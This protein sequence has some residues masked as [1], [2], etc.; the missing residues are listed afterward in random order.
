V[1]TSPESV[2]E[3]FQTCCSPPTRLLKPSASKIIKSTD[4]YGFK[5]NMLF[6]RGRLRSVLPRRVD[7]YQTLPRC[8]EP[9]CQYVNLFPHVHY[10]NTYSLLLSD[11][12]ETIDDFISRLQQIVASTAK[13]DANLPLYLYHLR[14]SLIARFQ[15]LDTVVDLDDA[16]SYATEAADLLPAAHPDLSAWLNDWSQPFFH[17]F[18]RLGE[19]KDLDNAILH[20]QRAVD[21][22]RDGDPL[23]P[24]LLI[25]LG[26][27]L[28]LRFRRVGQRVDADT[29]ISYQNRAVGLIP[30]RHPILPLHLLPLA[31]SYWRRFQVFGDL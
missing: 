15:L 27:L 24:S 17:R 18:E 21:L 12:L 8:F 16:I 2:A 19:M 3:R 5:Y 6:R 10:W 7:S 1:P 11:N 28:S 13:D 22:I 30:D 26:T 31:N 14:D 25:N 20:E 29:A 4:S 23:L 9:G